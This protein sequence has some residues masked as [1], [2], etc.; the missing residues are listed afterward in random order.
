MSLVGHTGSV[1]ALDFDE[2]SALLV[3]GSYDTTVR[4]WQVGRPR[5]NTATRPGK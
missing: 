5:P 1:T 3:S 4:L 2:P